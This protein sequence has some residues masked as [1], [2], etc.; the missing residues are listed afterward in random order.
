MS[1]GRSLSRAS[2][3]RGLAP[4]DGFCRM[5]FSTS[6][7]CAGEERT[8]RTERSVGEMT[9]RAG[10]SRDAWPRSRMH[11]AGGLVAPGVQPHS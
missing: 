5:G 3:H 6:S 7:G 2:T 11:V 10:V 8:R 9:A 1:S 4:R